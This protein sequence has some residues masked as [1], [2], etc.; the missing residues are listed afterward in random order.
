[1]PNVR[2]FFF[3]SSRRRHT[4]SLCDWS[5]DVC[6]SDLITPKG[7]QELSSEEKLLRA[8]FGEKAR[9]VKD[10]SLRLPN[11]ERGKV[12]GVKVFSRENG[13]ELQAGVI[14]QYHVSVAQMRK[15][16]MGDKMAGR[17]GNKGVIARILPVED[18]PY[19]AD[20]TPA[21]II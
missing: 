7:E 18:M 2:Y 11:G 21:D 17:H 8:I 20:G 1:M 6:S 3:F 13:D 12:V 10:T 19:L 4:R 16:T 15:I 14:E 5:S 9:D